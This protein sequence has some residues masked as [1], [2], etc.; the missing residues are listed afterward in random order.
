MNNAAKLGDKVSG[1]YGVTRV[2]GILI[3]PGSIM[4][5]WFVLNGQIVPEGTEGAQ[6]RCGLYIRNYKLVE[7]CPVELSWDDV[8]TL[9]NEPFLTAAALE[10]AR[11]VW[12]I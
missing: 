6:A 4:G 7:R 8:V 11:L 10:G 1:I 9:D 2:E 5:N 3:A 12:G